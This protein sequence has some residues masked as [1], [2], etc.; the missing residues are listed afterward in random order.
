MHRTQSFTLGAYAFSPSPSSQHSAA[1]FSP[2]IGSSVG[3]GAN[4]ALSPGSGTTSR[5][6]LRLHHERG[7]GSSS[8]GSI[9]SGIGSVLFDAHKPAAH[10]SKSR[11]SSL[12]AITPIQPS[13][14]HARRSPSQQL[15]GT[16]VSETSTSSLERD[17]SVELR[18]YHESTPPPPSALVASSTPSSD[19][20]SSDGSTYATHASTSGAAAVLRAP[21]IHRPSISLNQTLV[22]PPS[23][24]ASSITSGR[25]ASPLSARGSFITTSSG[26]ASAQAILAAQAVRTGTGVG[27]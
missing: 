23:S 13:E 4:A 1:L 11:G 10:A 7:A 22:V 21:G 17:S 27:R 2:D 8:G 14:G 26:L 15:Q 6:T 9:G 16:P 5:S 20:T 18:R 19:R 3:V 25:S 12:G 24:P